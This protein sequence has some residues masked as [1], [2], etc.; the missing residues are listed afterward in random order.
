[1]EVGA[2]DRVRTVIMD[3][4]I[5]KPIYHSDTMKDLIDRNC[6]EVYEIAKAGGYAFVPDETKEPLLKSPPDLRYDMVR[7]LHS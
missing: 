6:P 7:Q 2:P 5:G 1:M 3:K 4:L